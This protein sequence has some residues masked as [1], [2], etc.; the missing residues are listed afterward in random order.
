MNAQ[1]LANEAIMLPIEQR[2]LLA[3]MLLQSIN[4]KD[5]K[6][7][8]KWLNIAKQRLHELENGKVMGLHGEDVLSEAWKR[9]DG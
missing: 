6:N 9:L 5:E 3:D 1:E 8:I 4:N 2:V 7:Q